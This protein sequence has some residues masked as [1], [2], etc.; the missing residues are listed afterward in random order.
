MKIQLLLDFNTEYDTD[1]V[2]T[3]LKFIGF[4]KPIHS[5]FIQSLILF[6]T[7]SMDI[8]SFTATQGPKVLKESILA[9][10]KHCLLWTEMLQ[11]HDKA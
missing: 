10:I 9:V 1:V 5:T 7:K 4:R 11:A 6:Q 8:L 3:G 2:N